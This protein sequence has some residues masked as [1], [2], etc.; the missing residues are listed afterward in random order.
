[1]QTGIKAAIAAFAVAG[2]V[3]H[4]QAQDRLEIPLD[5]ARAIARQSLSDGH[6]GVALQLAQGLLQADPDDRDA[7]ILLAAAYAQLGQP[8]DSRRIGARAWRQS[9]TPAQ[10]YEAARLTALAASQADQLLLSQFWL[11]RALNDTSNEAEETQ[12]RN[13]VQL[14]RSR[15]PWRTSLSFGITPSN[16]IN[17]GSYKKTTQLGDITN[18]AYLRQLIGWGLYN[19]ATGELHVGDNQLALPGIEISGGIRTQYVLDSNETSATLLTAGI[20]GQTYRLNEEAAYN[21][22]GIHGSDF[23]SHRMDFGITHRFVLEGQS[24]PSSVAFNV[25]Q[26]WYAGE[27]WTTSYTLHGDHAWQLNPQSQLRVSGAASNLQYPK[28]NPNAVILSETIDWQYATDAGNQVGLSFSATQSR[29][30]TDDSNYDAYTIGATYTHGAPIFAGIAAQFG[31]FATD[32]RYD[33][34]FYGPGSRND[35]TLRANARF[36]LTEMEYYGFQPVI[37]VDTSRTASNIGRF[38]AKGFGIGFDIESSF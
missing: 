18:L 3:T 27:P 20:S 15:S 22:I 14:V 29:S 31:I 1:M 10:R 4:A 25:A 2:I 32:R 26:S 7:L 21:K 34:T 35:Q 24:L 19:P 23:A 28:D 30:D 17:G 33:E 37:T 8:A 12:T 6:P 13:D 5:E 11:R 36:A 9:D 38:N 16:N